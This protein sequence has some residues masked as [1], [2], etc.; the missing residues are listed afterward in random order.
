MSECHIRNKR[1]MTKNMKTIIYK[2]RS[3]KGANENKKWEICYI[4]WEC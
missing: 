2:V 1:K 4:R 3:V